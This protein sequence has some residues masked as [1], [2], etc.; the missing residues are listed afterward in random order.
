MFNKR[1]MGMLGLLLCFMLVAFGGCSE[2]REI[3]DSSNW[4]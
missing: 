2:E 1:I 4:R 3:T